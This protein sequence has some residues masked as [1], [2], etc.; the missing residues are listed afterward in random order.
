VPRLGSLF[1]GCGGLD[2]AFIGHGF[3]LAFV[4]EVDRHACAVL[5]RHHP[6][7][8]NVGDVKL[9]R[10]ERLPP[11]DVLTFGSPCQDISR[12]NTKS[13]CGLHDRRSGL[14]WQVV[15]LIAEMRREDNL[16]QLLVWE[17]VDALADPKWRNQYEEVLSA[18]GNH[19]YHHQTYVEMALEAGVPQLRKRT[20]TVLSREDVNFPSTAGRRGPVTTISDILVGELD[21]E[22]TP[23]VQSQLLK[24]LYRQRLG[25]VSRERTLRVHQVEAWLGMHPGR[26]PAEWAGKCVCYSPT[27]TCTPQVERI[28]TMTRQDA[29]WVLLPSGIR[30]RLTNRELERAFGFPDGH[31]SIGVRPDG[32]LY[33]LSDLQRRG[34]LGNAV[35]PA[36]VEGIARWASERFEEVMK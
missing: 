18:F 5:R 25:D 17:N 1:S 4:A 6:D 24:Q 34:L 27:Y 16:P 7:V 2:L 19:G 3:E 8:S 13:T 32:R 31:T 9:L 29:P 33:L 21:D 14:I 28:S 20:V 22:F 36:A 11:V 12:A 10:A 15:R 35:V 30:R 26:E 23:K